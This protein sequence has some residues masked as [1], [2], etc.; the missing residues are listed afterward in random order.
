MF[1]ATVTS[2]R[3]TSASGLGGGGE[4]GSVGGGREEGPSTDGEGGRD[5][6][7]SESKKLVVEALVEFWILLGFREGARI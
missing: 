3:Q 6:V 5:L 4:R 2:P 1:I 7:A